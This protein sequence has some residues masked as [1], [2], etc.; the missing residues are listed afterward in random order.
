M[1]KKIKH[2]AV[3]DSV[4]NVTESTIPTNISS[5]DIAKLN[6]YDKLVA[7]N[8]RMHQ[9]I[10]TYVQENIELRNKLESIAQNQANSSD[11]QNI[12]STKIKELEDQLAKLREENDEYL[13]KIS[14]LSFELAKTKAECEHSK[15]VDSVQH[16]KSST[17]TRHSTS[18]LHDMYLKSNGYDS[19][20]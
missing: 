15:H 12:D 7:E 2:N 10:E 9:Q 1:A 11:V 8:E 20:N 3:L 14:E 13:M 19:W 5:D 18:L 16:N 4:S 6:H 17:K